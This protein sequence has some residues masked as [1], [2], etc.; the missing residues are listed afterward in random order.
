MLKGKTIIELTDT[1]TGEVEYHEND[2]MV[3]NAIKH[4]YEPFGHYKSATKLLG[5]DYL[6]AYQTLL[7]GILLFDGEISEN[8][9]QLFAPA[10]TN[11]TAC[12]VYGVQNAGAGTCRGDF[13]VTESEV[14]LSERYVKY[15]YDFT[16]SQGN[17]TI[18]SVCLTG[19]MGGYNA[20]GSADPEF[21]NSGSGMYWFP[22]DTPVNFMGGV[23]GTG[24]KGKSISLGVTEF[25]FAVDPD[26]DILYYVR[27]NSSKSVSLI[28]RKGFFKSVSIF[29]TTS[30][31]GELIE[32]KDLDNFT[33]GLLSTGVLYYNYCLDDGCLYL[34]SAA[35][36]TL[37]NGGSFSIIK[38][39]V[40]TGNF[41][42][43]AMTNQTNAT[44][45]IADSTFVYGDY[46][47][48]N[49]SS[50][51]AKMY[52]IK[53]GNPTDVTELSVPEVCRYSGQFYPSFASA[54]R[55]W[56]EPYYHNYMS[57]LERC[58]VIDTETDE[59]KA[60]ENRYV[61]GAFASNVT[62][63]AVPVI[64][65]KECAYWRGDFLY[66]Q[67]YLA[68]INNLDSPVTKTADKTMKVTY[69]IQEHES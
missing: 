61:F 39:N 67:F 10:G 32:T 3:T 4:L 69:I 15:V 20:Y 47:Y 40:E 21:T 55:I 8:K 24:Y 46:I 29:Q 51:T 43:Y 45:Y 12:G 62:P 57:T 19:K 22:T 28:K 14:N 31:G 6:P 38:I 35:N 30:Q 48:L 11:L 25:L 36:T 33:T 34:Y 41:T 44:V 56:Y 5:T 60:T 58:Y 52:K 63:V 16:T 66:P 9:E 59:I 13:N 18:A 54:G 1:K 26:N 50:S 37:S 23:S 27:V 65:H 42:E 64:G 17:G 53:I 68:T 7:G 2:N 49:A